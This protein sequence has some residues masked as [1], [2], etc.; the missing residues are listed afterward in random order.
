MTKPASE[1]APLVHSYSP[2]LTPELI[3]R[4][5]RKKNFPALPN[6]SNGKTN[7][8]E[9]EDF[10]F[11]RNLQFEAIHFFY[12]D[13]IYKYALR[14]TN[15]PDEALEIVAQTFFNLY[16]ITKPVRSNIRSY[17]YQTAYHKVCDYARERHR[18][19]V[20]SAMPQVEHTRDDGRH[21]QTEHVALINLEFEGVLTHF[22]GLTADQKH[23]LI[24]RFVA[25]F[26]IREVAE[27]M[28]KE[29]SDIKSLQY[30]GIKNL[31]KLGVR[32]LPELGDL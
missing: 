7:S 29:M 6:L 17:L 4:M 2:Q 10:T 20:F 31:K 22:N 8:K 27:I 30:R 1:A 11:K 25:G 26:K 5:I 32:N 24:L 9:I 13:A 12:R 14:L 16:N 3:K 23:V 28:G 15:D 19:P 18:Y 21:Q